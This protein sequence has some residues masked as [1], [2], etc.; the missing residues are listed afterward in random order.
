MS[1]L[2]LGALGF[3]ASAQAQ[4]PKTSPTASPQA[5]AAVS[6]SAAGAAATTSP[7]GAA[8]TKKQGAAGKNAGNVT[9][10]DRAFMRKAAKAGKTEI[11]MGKMAAEK[12]QSDDVKNFGKQMVTDHSD[13]NKEL[14]EIAKGKGARLAPRAPK[15]QWKSDKE[16][17]EMMVKDHEKALALFQ[18]EAQE[19]DDADLKA[20]AD[21]TAKTV[22]KHLDQAKQ[23]QGKLQ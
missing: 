22:Q 13:A 9:P 23:I 15:D 10:K 17:M 12:A 1:A 8:E 14:M 11:E 19:G 18:K 20:F 21:K 6:A 4:N 5:S 2:A 3:I 16:Y 7:T